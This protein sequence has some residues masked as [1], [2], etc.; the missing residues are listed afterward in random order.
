MKEYFESLPTDILNLWPESQTKYLYVPD[1]N[2]KSNLL[3]LEQIK[4]KY[5]RLS[6]YSLY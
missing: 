6:I 3:K 5:L 4:F 1:M 2:S